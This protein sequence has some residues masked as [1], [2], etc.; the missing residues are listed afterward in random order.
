MAPLIKK[1]QEPKKEVKKEVKEAPKKKE[2]N[3]DLDVFKAKVNPLD[4]LPESKFSLFDFKT[5]FVNHED[6]KS[7]MKEFWSTFDKEGY[8]LWQ[9]KYDKYE[10]EGEK[11]HMTNNLV[12][13][14]IQ[15]LDTFRKYSFGVHGVYG[16]E[17]KLD[18]KGCWVWRG[19]EIPFEMT[20]HVSYEYNFYTRLDSEKEKDRQLVEDYWCGQT[21]D[22]SVVD[23]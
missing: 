14:F 23:G 3:K 10:G 8:S 11:L 4:E 16:D 21:E 9:I 15:R 5:L 13:G 18:I 17:P 2:E 19:T 22:E 1:E 20:D 6:K 12:G 7:A